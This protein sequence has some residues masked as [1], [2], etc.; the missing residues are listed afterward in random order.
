[1]APLLEI[2]V[3]ENGGKIP[4]LNEYIMFFVD[5]LYILVVSANPMILVYVKLRYLMGM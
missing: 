1:M 3:F 5:L 4:C 2:I